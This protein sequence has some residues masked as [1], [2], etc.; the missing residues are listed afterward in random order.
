[1]PLALS[2]PLCA[3]TPVLSVLQPLTISICLPSAAV[4]S[5]EPSLSKMEFTKLE[6]DLPVGPVAWISPVMEDREADEQ[7]EVTG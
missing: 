5:D 7:M 3:L 1:M 4:L 2:F 6:R